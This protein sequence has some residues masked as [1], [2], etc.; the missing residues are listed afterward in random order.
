MKSGVPERASRGLPTLELLI[1]LQFLDQ[2]EETVCCIPQPPSYTLREDLPEKEQLEDVSPYH[3]MNPSNGSDA[4][5]QPTSLPT[6]T[7]V[8]VC[9]VKP[10]KPLWVWISCTALLQLWR[11]AEEHVMNRY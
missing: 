11:Q 2:P 4:Q 10:P 8:A 3:S 1:Y 7:D 6:F 9:S 5:Q